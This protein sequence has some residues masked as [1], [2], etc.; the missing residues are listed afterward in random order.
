MARKPAVLVTGANGEIG[1]GL[2]HRLADLGTFDILAL[3]VR[4][5]ETDLARR[6]AATVVGDVLDRHLLDRA[7]GEF[8]ISVIFHLAAILS[9]RA[10][11][12]PETAHEVNVQGTLNLLHLAVEE[13][14]SIGRPVKFL[15]PSSIAVYGLGSRSAKRAAGRVAED[16]GL[17]PI[18]MYCCGK[19]YCDHL[20]RYDARHYRQLAAQSQPAGVDFRSIRFPGLI[21]AFTTPS[22]GTSDYAPEML[23]AASRRR[24]S[25]L[26]G[27]QGRD[28]PPR[29]SSCTPSHSGSRPRSTRSAT[30]ASG[31]TNA[32]SRALRPLGSP[33]AVA[34]C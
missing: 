19:L 32:S 28:R 16:A 4:P 23:H 13:A 26:S 6:C 11:F 27:R 5:L 15:F 33:W 2:I 3:D 14:R 31:R 8:E 18:T 21:S 29:K 10:E 24:P 34:R 20:G 7:M 22:G 9:S 17:A 30:P 25:G 12:V 1:H